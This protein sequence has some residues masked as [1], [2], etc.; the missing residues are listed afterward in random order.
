MNQRF[1][2]LS[3]ILTFA[4][5]AFAQREY[6]NYSQNEGTIYVKVSDG[7]YEFKPFNKKIMHTTFIP[8]SIEITKYNFGVEMEAEKVKFLI[9]DG[10]QE[11]VIETPGLK[12][13]IS[14]SPFNVAYY[15]HSNLIIREKNGYAR[16]D[17]T[18]MVDF[19]LS[20]DEVLFGGGARALGMNRRGNLLK[21]YNRAHYGYETHSELMN[22]SLPMVISSNLY[23]V[24]FDNPSSGLLDLDRNNDNTLRYETE[25]GCVNYYVV[26][27]K[28]W[29]ELT[30]LN[31]LLTGRQPLLPRWALGNFSSRFGYHSQN[32][33]MSTI[34]KYE[35]SNIPVDAIIID[36]YWFGKEIFNEMG[37]LDWYKD[38]FPE[39]QK[40]IETLANKGIKTILVTEP[41]ILTTSNKW[42]EAVDNKVLGLDSL[43]N[44]YTYDF[45]F[46][47]TGLV[48]I[49]KPEARDWFW[50]IYKDLTKQGISGWWGDLG[51][52]EVH[53]SDLLHVNG[54]ADDIH[55]AY[56]HE[57]AKMIYEGY[58][59]DFPEQRPFILMRAGY[60]GSQRYG[61]IPWTGDVSRSWGGLIP[62]V[63]LSLQMGMQGLAFM[64]SD[65]G[66]FA[67]GDSLDNELY[68]RWLQ[69]G[70]FQPIFRPHAQEQ[71][72]PEPVFQTPA[73]KKLAKK[74]IELRYKL[75]PYNY[76]LA[77]INH[78][79]G[80]PLMLPLFFNETDNTELLS[81]DKAYMWGDAFLVSPIKQ[82]GEKE[83]SFY[84]PKMNSWID[85]HTDKK[86]VGGQEISVETT[87]ENIPVFVKAG[88]F[89]PMSK[90]EG[91]ISTYSLENFEIHYYFDEKSTNITYNLYND[92]GLTPNAEAK[93]L[94]ENYLFTSSTS[95]KELKFTVIKTVD[96][97]YKSP[98]KNI[99]DFV[100]HTLDSEPKK[101]IINGTK[102][103]KTDWVYNE[104]NQKL[105]FTITIQK[106]KEIII[107]F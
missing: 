43:G 40:M 18:Q 10:Q 105:T 23:T 39:P 104:I 53:P 85:F 31:T 37:N 19:N 7:T 30:E 97:Y 32:E 91:N 44:P 55:N 74:A 3:L 47:N 96:K 2:F 100:I 106:R 86:Y 84:L 6:V 61:M 11:L 58:K 81:Y 35:K 15:Y 99:I 41:F 67:G 78:K 46:G 107:S 16:T 76:N 62:Q 27:A 4:I 83:H 14:K 51:E 80:K 72:A 21:L 13:K 64:H 69:Y 70:V 54:T 59:K 33:V 68:T 36:I 98:E 89:I 102:L 82:A 24:F 28:D 71:I 52:P 63:E 20:T 56:G 57:W 66:G 45:Y 75:L 9:K 5:S 25:G 42:Q 50:D 101:V 93:A 77:Y 60:A 12:V 73:T 29:Y 22:Y 92:D 95:E 38:S 49:F 79:T 1:L 65:L 17:T 34:D 90:T 26:K 87:I 94:S 8:D 88:S 48:D 103:N